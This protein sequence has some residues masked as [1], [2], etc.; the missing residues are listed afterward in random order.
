MT[1]QEIAIKCP[2]QEQYRLIINMESLLVDSFLES[3]I[4]IRYDFH[5]LKI[6]E[7]FVECRLIQLD[8]S[9][10]K[11]SNPLVKEIADVTTAF[12]QMFTEIHFKIT[13]KGEIIEVINLPIILEKW[14]RVKQEMLAATSQNEDVKKLISLNDSIFTNST[15][16]IQA[17]QAN[18]FLSFYFNHIYGNK[19]PFEN[20]SIKPNFFNTA[21]IEWVTS[22]K[23]SEKSTSNSIFIDL[24]SEPIY[25]LPAD[26]YKKAYASFAEKID[27]SKL[28]T[29]INEKG[30]YQ[31]DTQTGKLIRAEINRIE[32]ADQSL[33][34]KLT[35]SLITESLYQ[36]QLQTSPKRYKTLSGIN[37]KNNSEKL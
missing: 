37:E 10:S 16:I 8:R 17:I 13:I 33:Y 3:T 4:E 18:E 27:I 35:Y 29:K 6:T 19:L 25:M 23:I 12:N 20:K 7:S 9:L 31:I 15:K 11:A 2:F 28:F 22:A 34:T 5:I 24:K 32:R 14:S 1:N 30:K 26:F 21:Y 36:E